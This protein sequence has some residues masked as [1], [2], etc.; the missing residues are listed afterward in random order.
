MDPTVT[1]GNPTNQKVVDSQREEVSLVGQTADK[2]GRPKFNRTRRVPKIIKDKAGR[3]RPVRE[4]NR[5]KAKLCQT[6][7]VPRIIRAR[8]A[9]TRPV[10]KANRVKAKLC[11]TGRVLKIT[12]DKAGRTKPVPKAN[13]VKAKLSRTGRVLGLIKPRPGGIR[14]VRK[15]IKAGPSWNPRVPRV[16]GTRP[17]YAGPV[18]K[19]KRVGQ[20]RT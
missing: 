12:Q 8:A 20:R 3:T 15:A 2:P 13:R 4:A 18:P 19:A 7:R 6:G 1:E 5:G 14:L 11:Q 10:R 9:R 17:D 16:S